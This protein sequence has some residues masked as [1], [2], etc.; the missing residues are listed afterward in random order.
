MLHRREISSRPRRV[1]WREILIRR[2]LNPRD[3]PLVPNAIE[4]AARISRA[5][6]E[7]SVF[8]AF[9]ANRDAKIRRDANVR[10]LTRAPV[11]LSRDQKLDQSDYRGTCIRARDDFSTR[12]FLAPRI[13]FFSV[14]KWDI[15]RC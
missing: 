9:S 2:A 6:R 8:S 13:C 1:G 5:A 12:S 14:R 15:N 10:Q 4:R 7:R 3:P 11:Y